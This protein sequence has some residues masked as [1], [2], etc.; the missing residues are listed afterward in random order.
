MG[1]KGFNAKGTVMLIFLLERNP[2][3]REDLEPVVRARLQHQGGDH[4]H[5]GD[6]HHSALS[7]T[8]ELLQMTFL[9]LFF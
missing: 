2:G 4:D 8:L 3:S 1:S 6:R 5:P 9:R 7:F